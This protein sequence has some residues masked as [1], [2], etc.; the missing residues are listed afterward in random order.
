MKRSPLTGRFEGE[1]S[2]GERLRFRRIDGG[3][4]KWIPPLRL[5]RIEESWEL[6]GVRGDEEGARGFD[7]LKLSLRS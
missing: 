6:R 7:P 3:E 4:L 1:S 5:P 2:G